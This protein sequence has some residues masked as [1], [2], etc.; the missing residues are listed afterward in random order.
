MNALRY[1][2]VHYYFTVLYITARYITVSYIAL[3]YITGVLLMMQ[4]Q[5]MV[6]GSDRSRFTDIAYTGKR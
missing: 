5:S 4:D 3:L 6:F 1:T 2:N